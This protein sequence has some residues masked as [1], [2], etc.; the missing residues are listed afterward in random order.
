MDMIMSSAYIRVAGR[1]KVEGKWGPFCKR[2]VPQMLNVAFAIFF[3]RLR[4][5][6]LQK[7]QMAPSDA[8]ETPE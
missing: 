1:V 6:F 4:S 8:P 3:L 2:G 5:D 7:P